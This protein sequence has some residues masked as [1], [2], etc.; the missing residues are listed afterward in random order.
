MSLLASV[1][2]LAALL[3]P[4]TGTA[5]ANHGDGK[6]DVTP[7]TPTRGVGV[8]HTITARL[9][10]QDLAGDPENCDFDFPATNAS[11]AIRIRFENENGANDPDDSISRL[12]PDRSCSV[13]P[14]SEPASQ[15]S[16]SY[17][18]TAS[19]VDTWRAWIDHDDS[20]ATDESDTAEGRNET[21]T[22]G[23]P[24]DLCGSLPGPAEPD[25]TDVVNVTWSGGA[26]AQ[27]DCDDATGP[28]T[29][30]E[31]NPSGG[32]SGNETY[33]CEV[34]DAQG[35]LTFDADP[36]T[37]GNQQ[38][39]MHAENRNGI[40]DPDNPDG[41]TYGSEDYG[42]NIGRPLTGSEVPGKCNIPV[43]QNEGE[44][45][46]AVICFWVGTQDQPTGMSLCGPGNEP[47]EE[48]QAGNGSDTGND[49]A[50]QVDITWQESNSGEG[51]LDAEPETDTNP[52]G[53]D[54]TITGTIYDQFGVPA[55]EN[56]TINFEFFTGSASDTD[57]NT[58]VSAD[59]ACTT[60]NSS[61][62]T[63]TYTSA[64]AGRDLVCAWVHDA[65]SMTGSNQG[66]TCDGEGLLDAD[67]TAGSAD[68]PEPATDD[69][70]VV[71]KTWTNDPAA[72]QLDCGQENDKTRRTRSN[73]IACTATDGSNGIANTNIDVEITGANDPDGNSQASP[74][75][76]CTTNGSGVCSVTHGGS[77][78]NSLGKTSY[79]AWI[80]SDFFNQ[81]PEADQGEQRDESTPAGAG[82]IAEPDGTDVMETT[83][84]PV[85]K[86]TISLDSNRN[87][88][89]GSE[90][91][92]L[93]GHQRR[94]R[95]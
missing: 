34:R 6:L 81:T 84:I 41:E 56:T 42:C 95:L 5:Q 11:G 43:T 75:L 93:R 65:P 7:E 86:R 89:G 33:A 55:Q 12:T 2:I 67:D 9:C 70:D 83:W 29:E 91:Q 22:P 26:P 35:N 71:S 90:S 14:N 19:G 15:C 52:K 37:D 38:I 13:F 46:T 68:P 59:K 16:I 47:T 60:V 51:G 1:A 88:Q 18:G 30:R 44:E 20:A 57:G 63:V 25:C 87:S 79:R 73:V 21:Q 74:D 49:L 72:T 48:N 92:V 69:V 27:V 61:T 32:G 76:S 4:L 66:G 39:R 78:S 31:N 36:N 62:C 3:V 64:N 40:N 58:P 28:D 53:T 77:S 54:R 85:A 8:T 17:V 10:E 82:N 80:D 45:G 94:S 24:G 50:D 23:A